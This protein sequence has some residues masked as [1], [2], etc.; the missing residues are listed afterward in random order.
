MLRQGR[1]RE[2]AGD[3]LAEEDRVDALGAPQGIGVVEEGAG[4][5]VVGE[6]APLAVEVQQLAVGRDVPAS[7]RQARQNGVS[8]RR[9]KRKWRARNQRT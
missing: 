1:R 8:S 9:L 7:A 3:A 6:R 5:G 2:P 4:G